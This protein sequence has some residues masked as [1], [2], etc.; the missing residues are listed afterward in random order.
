[1]ESADEF[2][3][4]ENE[5]PNIISSNNACWQQHELVRLF[6]SVKSEV[7]ESQSYWVI[8]LTLYIH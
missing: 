5:K 4:I 6:E 3:Y 8:W 1:M 7:F 2:V